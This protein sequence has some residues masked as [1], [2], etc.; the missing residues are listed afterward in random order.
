LLQQSAFGLSSNAGGKI[1]TILQWLDT[2][3]PTRVGIATRMKSS[4]VFPMF[5]AFGVVVV[6]LILS[7]LVI[8]L[9][10]V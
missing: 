6:F 4:H 7:R 1:T 3:D 2:T 9:S 5:V 8:Q 10:D